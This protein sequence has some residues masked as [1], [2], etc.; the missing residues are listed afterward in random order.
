M[1][2]DN[3]KETKPQ[4]SRSGTLAKLALAAKGELNEETNLTNQN[5]KVEPV[6]TGDANEDDTITPEIFPSEKE[7]FESNDFETLLRGIPLSDE[8]TKEAKEEFVNCLSGAKSGDYDAKTYV[9]VDKEVKEIFALIKTATGVDSMKLISFILE[10]W[11][12][13]NSM[14]IKNLMRSNKYL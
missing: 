4:G 2:K 7:E 10:Q 3:K 6:N 14:I 11:I 9:Y 5:V 13:K 8:I 12:N 1:N